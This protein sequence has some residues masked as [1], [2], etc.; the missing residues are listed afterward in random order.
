MELRDKLVNIINTENKKDPLT[1]VQIAKFLSTTRENITNLRKELNISN[2]RQRRYPYLKSAISTILQK[3]KNISISE[4]TRELMTEG[5]NISRR[6]VEELLPKES[7]EMEVV[8]ET[9]EES[10]DPFETLIGNKGSLRNAVEQAKSAI[11]YPPKGLPTLIVGE[12]GVGKSLFSRHMYEFAKQ[13]KI[14]KE[15]S[16]FVVFNCADYSDNPQLLLSLLFGYKK[17]AFTGA[18]YDA[19][20]LV[21]EADE[22]VLFLDEIHRLP[23]KG[24]EILFSILDRG[25]F[26]RLGETNAERKV[27]IMLIGAT[28]ENVETNLLLT[29]RR[30]IPML[31]TL[32]PLHDRLLKEKIDLIY[33]IF[34]QECNRINA[35]IFVDKNV[36]EILAL[37]KFSGNIGQLQNMIQV[38][39]ARAFMKFI[40]SKD[41]DSESIVV[42]DI[43]EVLKLK[44]SF[45]DAAFQEVEYTEIRKYL[46]NAIFIPFNLEE[47][48]VKGNLL[49]DKYI[50]PEDI[51]K[52]IEKKYYD[53]KSLDIEDIDIENILWTFILNRFADLKFNL[54]S[55]E[56]IFSMSDLNSFVNDSLVKLVKELMND[57][58]EKNIN[59]EVNKNMFKYLAIHL[60]EAIKRI[61]LNQ[62]IINVNLEKIKIDF[63]KEYEI[64]KSFAIKIEE[65]IGIKIPDDEIGFITLYIKSALKN[66]AKK[67]KVGLIIISHGRIATETVN[68][69]KELL[70]V[71]FPVAID[72]PL[73]EK[74]INIYNKAVE[75]SKIIDQ[76]KGILFLVDIGSLTNIGQIV[77]KRTNI[78]TK[79]IDRVDLLMALEAAR[80]V[81]MGEEELD[82]IFFSLL[83]DRMGYNYELE[84]HIDKS[85]AIVTLCLTG[86]GTAKYISKTLEE[87]YDNTKCYQ[88]SALD[89]NLFCKIE[90]IKETSN[91]LAIVGTI[92][93]KVPGI[94]F[95]PYNKEVF[96]NLDIYLSKSKQQDDRPIKSYERMLD[97][98]L[99]I[100]EPDIY[101]KKDLL[102]YV[103]SILINKEYVEKDYLDSV[104]HREEMLPTYSKGF[105]G[106]PHGDSSTVNSTRFVFVKLKNPIDWGV[107][108]VNFIFMPVF[109]ANDK[110]IVKNVL[111]ILKDEEFMNNANKC[112]N[113]DAFKKIIFDKFKHL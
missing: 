19:P 24:Q 108:N 109:Q 41:E 50:L 89:E 23:P 30:R 6:V 86:E 83:K 28:T 54:D 4:I 90:N 101:F 85:N 25:K 8:E 20:G 21:E 64:S 62:K 63:S 5:F 61:K 103:C 79:T 93:P 98:D 78:N 70:G 94:N 43:N 95:I 31:I 96:K 105:I 51:Y 77:N 34:Q 71:K 59:L 22:G 104:L 29:F 48:L 106:V 13:K 12:S 60:E 3:N 15:S 107:G 14:I 57:I 91:I 55:S 39:C 67:D 66:E 73:D 87:K 113:K 36:I 84:K 11:L 7:L 17:G 44:D 65:S 1:D 97:E 32:P 2:S 72:M 10:N 46:K 9:E 38:L 99:V 18:E 42:V 58:V 45:K 40:N 82:E 92:N 76:G 26:R 81:S 53:L 69:V 33:N 88:M 102:E 49:S 16:N 80:K 75:L 52:T 111:E 112:F 100:F 68:V 47:A 35:K 110:E 27:S 74:P 37:K 56:D